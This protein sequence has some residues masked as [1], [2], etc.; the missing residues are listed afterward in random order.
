MTTTR[1]PTPARLRPADLARLAAVGLRT[2]KLRAGLSALG[3]AIGVAAIVAVLGLSAS[4]QAGLLAEIRALGTNLLTVENGQAIGG[5]T[6]ERPQLGH[7]RPAAGLGR[8][9]RRRCADR[10]LRRAAARTQGRPPV[11]HPGPVDALTPSHSELS[12][13]SRDQAS[14]RRSQ[15]A[16][17]AV[18]IASRSARLGTELP[19]LIRRRRTVLADRWRA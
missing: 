15:P 2:R 1:T 8:R 16:A 12:R 3:I 14:R 11:T 19:I 9:A 10:R 4:S 7:R 5:G 17:P 13:A 6:A 18:T